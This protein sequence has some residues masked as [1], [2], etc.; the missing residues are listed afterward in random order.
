MD[1][2][3]LPTSTRKELLELLD[4]AYLVKPANELADKTL[5][6]FKEKS[7]KFKGMANQIKGLPLAV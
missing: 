5:A 2:L 3:S 4:P 7:E 1:E 6:G